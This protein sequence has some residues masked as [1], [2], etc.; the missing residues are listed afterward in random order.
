MVELMIVIGIIFLLATIITTGVF[1]GVASAR[2]ATC[3]SNQKQISVAIYAYMNDYDETYPL[4][5]AGNFRYATIGYYPK[6]GTA[7]I[8]EKQGLFWNEIVQPYSADPVKLAC[9][10][11]VRTDQNNSSKRLAFT[12]YSLNGFLFNHVNVHT[13]TSLKPF[14]ISATLSPTAS[15]LLAET[16]NGAFMTVFPDRKTSRDPIGSLY[17]FL[18]DYPLL[19]HGL[20][21]GT[22]HSGGANYIFIDGH[23]KWLKPDVFYDHS[24]RFFQD[25]GASGSPTFF[26]AF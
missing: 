4:A 23:A 16:R 19:L 18:S 9:P 22:R 24:E 10:E 14:D 12:G 1:S 20:E 13:N 7:M 3:L 21:A 11:N 6:H 17:Y 25:G 15:V 5:Y 2:K 26:I 8:A